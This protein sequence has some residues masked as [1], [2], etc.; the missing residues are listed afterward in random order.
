[1][2]KACITTMAEKLTGR[3]C[4]RCSH[5]YRGKCIHRDGRMFA[6]CWQ[7]V[8]RPGFE[9]RKPRYLRT[10]CKLT[11]HEQ[12]ELG[13][14]KQVL[15]EA[16]DTAR[17]GGLLEDWAMREIDCRKCLNLLGQNLDGPGDC[18][19]RCKIYGPDPAKATAACARDRFVN[20]RPCEWNPITK[21]NPGT[22]VWLVERDE[23]GD[24]VEVSGFLFLA[25]VAGAVIVT[26]RV[27][28]RETL[29]S[30]M[31]YHIEETMINE[32]TQLHVYPAA[33]CYLRKADADNALG[34]GG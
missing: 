1:M 11:T 12:H 15:Q 19:P 29:D 6:K 13:K 5:N 14:I 4:S 9:K 27:Y 24:A 10:E 16:G 34:M 31:E 20:Y 23:N 2:I 28:G 22:T 32:E 26:P 21:C 3:K 25:Q 8:T 7:S 17:G 30:V 33:D 18:A